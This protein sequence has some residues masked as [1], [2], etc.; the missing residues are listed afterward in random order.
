LSQPAGSLYTAQ[1][2]ERKRKREGQRKR[3]YAD[4]GQRDRGKFP[5]PPL[6]EQPQYTQS[7]QDIL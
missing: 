3:K 4:M 1:R 6:K 2:E 7:P 5:T